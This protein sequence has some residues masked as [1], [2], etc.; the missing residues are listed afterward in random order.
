MTWASGEASV[1]TVDATGLVK[2]AGNG[3]ATITATAGAASG[4]ASVTVEQAARSVAISPATETL[5]TG[6][7]LR[8]RAAALDT[9]GHAVAGVEFSWA[10]SDTTVATVDADGAGDERRRGRGGGDG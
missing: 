2:A 10:S 1:A 9:N 5:L 8:L 6:D 7:T 4:S 3:T